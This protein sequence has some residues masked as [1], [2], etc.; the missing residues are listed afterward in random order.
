ML[1]GMLAEADEITAV[2][3]PDGSVVEKDDGPRAGVTYEAIADLKPDEWQHFI[4]VETVNTLE[5]Q[6]NL[7]AGKAHTTRQKLSVKP[8]P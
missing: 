1:A 6:I 8:R 2:T 5:N 3:A 7:P 4:C